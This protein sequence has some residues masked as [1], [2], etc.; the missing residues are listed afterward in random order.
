MALGK[1]PKKRQQ[2]RVDEGS[3][4][5]RL[6]KKARLRL[7]VRSIK[8]TDLHF[9]PLGKELLELPTIKKPLPEVDPSKVNPNL[10]VP[11][12]P[13]MNALN[14]LLDP[15]S[16]KYRIHPILAAISTLYP[17]QMSPIKL[18]GLYQYFG[19]R[20]YCGTHPVQAAWKLT[21]AHCSSITPCKSVPTGTL[22]SLDISTDANIDG[23]IA[24]NQPTLVLNKK[25]RLRLFVRSIKWTDLHFGSLE[26][27]ELPT[28]KKPLPEVDPSKVNPN[29]P[30]PV[31]RLM[32][33]L[34]DLLDPKS[35]KYRIHPILA[36]I[37]T[38]YPDQMSPIKLTGLYQYFGGRAYCGTH[39]VQAAWKLTPVTP[40]HCSSITPCESVPTGTLDS[41]DISTVAN[42]GGGIA[43]NQPTLVYVD[44]KSVAAMRCEMSGV[45]RCNASVRRH[46]KLSYRKAVPSIT[47]EDPFIAAVM[48]ALAQRPFY[49]EPVPSA[50]GLFLSS[51][52]SCSLKEPQF[53]D[54]TVHILTVDD[55]EPSE[56]YFIVYKGLV[57]K[58]LLYKLHEPTKNR[59]AAGDATLA[60]TMGKKRGM[61]IESTRVLL[62]PILGLKERLGKALGKEIVG[63]FDENNIE[64]W[65]QNPNPNGGSLKEREHKRQKISSSSTS[66][67]DGGKSSGETKKPGVDAMFVRE[68]VSKASGFT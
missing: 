43:S 10:P 67:K 34:N 60:G 58:E 47:K 54:V 63:P 65:D 41:L 32:N 18:T 20:A 38:L 15:K 29:L 48:L 26:L 1:L 2:T 11:V 61:Y 9:G 28:I 46:K 14:D 62:W 50:D 33:A 17:D 8:W 3:L 37:S 35:M 13:L 16:M 57:T 31:Q 56:P 42:I 68:A 64:M 53:H 39:P 22:D 44:P 27:L 30:V 52:A 55:K 23:G 19:G 49:R 59:R 5:D 24:S 21:P 25:A 36:A 45:G 6:N 66:S 40:A 12:Q 51:S 7:F 4:S